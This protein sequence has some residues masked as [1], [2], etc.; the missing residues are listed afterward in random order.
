MCGR[1]LPGREGGGDGRVGEGGGG[2]AC[3]GRD[4]GGGCGGVRARARAGA[5][6]RHCGAAGARCKGGLD[7]GC[8]EGG[9]RASGVRRPG[10]GAVAGR[11]RELALALARA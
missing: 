6:R 2:G 5:G 4:G 9:R 1:A 8:L 10:E 3:R 11:G 7:V